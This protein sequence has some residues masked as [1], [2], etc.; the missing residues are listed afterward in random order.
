MS[1]PTPPRG[2]RLIDPEKDA[3]KRDGD[4]FNKTGK[5]WFPVDFPDSEFFPY[6]SYARKVEIPEGYEELP[7]GE[8]VPNGGRLWDHEEGEWR[9]SMQVGD[10]PYKFYF[11][12]RP[13]ASTAKADPTPLASR[14]AELERENKELRAKLES[15]PDAIGKFTAESFREMLKKGGVL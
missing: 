9:E 4:L 1:T 5:D 10:A 3:P 6:C 8:K 11:Y 13:K 14:V 7:K 2:Y 12:I 15:I